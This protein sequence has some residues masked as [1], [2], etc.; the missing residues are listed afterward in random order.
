MNLVNKVEGLY[1]PT[2]L[3]HEGVGNTVCEQPPVF[4]IQSN[5]T[6]SKTYQV[7][8]VFKLRH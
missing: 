2:A 1:G 6:T 7:F 5:L 3:R 4:E 8:P